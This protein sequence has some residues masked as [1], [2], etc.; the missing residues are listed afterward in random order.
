MLFLIFVKISSIQLKMFIIFQFLKT[1]CSNSINQNILT[2]RKKVSYHLGPNKY[3]IVQGTY[4]ID[5]S[6][7]VPYKA[8][9]VSLHITYDFFKN[10]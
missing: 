8:A 7:N 10:K 5:R 1:T 2:S 9:N 4:Y 6:Q 3:H